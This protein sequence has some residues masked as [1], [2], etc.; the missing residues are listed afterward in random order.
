M[1]WTTSPQ[2]CW[3]TVWQ[4]SKLLYTSIRAAPA[5]AARKSSAVANEQ[6]TKRVDRMFGI[7]CWA[8]ALVSDISRGWGHT[9]QAET[10]ICAHTHTST[11]GGVTD[12]SSCTF[13]L[14]SL[15][16]VLIWSL[17]A[18]RCTEMTRHRYLYRPF[19]VCQH[20]LGN[21]AWSCSRQPTESRLDQIVCL[22]VRLYCRQ[23]YWLSFIGHIVPF[24]RGKS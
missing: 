8:A 18:L 3:C 23:V 24:A 5:A 12:V 6:K 7:H 15:S 19:S 1:S 4:Q 2:A 9:M 21:T 20:T 16:S 17:G 22:Q 11:E 10:L 14:F 13:N